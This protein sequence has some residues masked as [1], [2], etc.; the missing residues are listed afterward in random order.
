MRRMQPACHARATTGHAAAVPPS[1]TDIPHEASSGIDDS[2][3]R[4]GPRRARDLPQSG[5]RLL[6]PSD[7]GAGTPGI[8][9]SG[10]PLRH[11]CRRRVDHGDGEWVND[12][13]HGQHFK[14]WFLRVVFFTSQT[15]TR[16]PS[17]L[18]LTP[19]RA[20]SSSSRSN[21]WRIASVTRA[22]AVEGVE[23]GDTIGA[24]NHRLAIPGE[25]PRAQLGRGCGDGGIA[26]GPII[27][28]PGEQPHRVADAANLQP[29][30]V[31]FDLVDPLR[32]RGRLGG[33]GGD[34]RRD[35]SVATRHATKVAACPT[36]QQR[37]KCR[38]RG[39]VS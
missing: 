19:T 35:V 12:R 21:L 4:G 26:L 24:A 27:A 16:R 20:P 22:A 7:Q 39:I 8:S 15:N 14:A 18:P 1:F 11:H 37:P 5:E 17:M 36:G 10:R 32:P 31:V 28:A 2:G 33:A 25:G 13:T 30:A 9:D 23:H 29:V 38:R 6:R 34:A 3:G